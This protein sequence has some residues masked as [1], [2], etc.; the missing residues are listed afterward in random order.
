MDEQFSQ[1]I[2]VIAGQA[3]TVA[4]GFQERSLS[5]PRLLRAQARF[6]GTSSVVVLAGLVVIIATV[7]SI[8]LQLVAWAVLT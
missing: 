2:E 1:P 5:H 8:V 7:V 3:V 4:P 6:S